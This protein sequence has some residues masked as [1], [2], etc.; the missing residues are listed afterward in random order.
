[1]HKEFLHIYICP[2]NCKGLVRNA[3][4][5]KV[6]MVLTNSKGWDEWMETIKTASMRSGIWEYINPSIAWA[7]RKVLLKPDVIDRHI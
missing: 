2:A 5:S 4:L 7:D 3:N 1:M 6:G